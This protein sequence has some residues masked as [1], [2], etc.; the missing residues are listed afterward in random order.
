[1]S[2]PSF[3][4]IIG[5]DKKTFTLHSEMVAC[6]SA[7]LHTLVHG[8]FKEA[9]ERCIRWPEVDKDTF[10]RFTEYIY[11]GWYTPASPV[12]ARETQPG[13]LRSYLVHEEP[14]AP[15]DAQGPPPPKR[16]RKCRDSALWAKFKK[17]YLNQSTIEPFILDQPYEDCTGVFLCHAKMYVFA[18]YYGIGKLKTMALA[19]LRQSLELFYIHAERIGDV[20]NLIEYIYVNTSKQERRTDPMRNL[21][22]IY[23]ACKME[24]LWESHRFR[25]AFNMLDGFSE[26]VITRLMKRL[27]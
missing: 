18:E 14:D 25:R 3:T 15:R 5:P 24:S 6:Q 1:M 19:N 23:A 22:C 21:V 8:P 4:F 7:A 17:G 9:E 11:T 16:P 12:I 13:E 10:V 27:D 20:V 2:S 26:R